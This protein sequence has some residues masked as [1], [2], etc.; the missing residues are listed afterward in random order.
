MKA[1]HIPDLIE[2]ENK[3]FSKPWTY[4]GF[5]A[6]LENETA[7]FF[8]AI[9]DNRIVGY[10]GFHVILDEGYIANIAVS[11]E[12][13]RNGTGSALLGHAVKISREKNL[14]FLSLEVRKS[15][16]NAI[17]LYRKFGFDIVGER[18]NFYSA[19]TENGYIMTLTFNR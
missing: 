13:R 11:P 17:R 12:F 16:E 15:N 9:K 7:N 1:E 2:I 6:E 19:P 8:T 5:K 18:K 3:C 14:A 10:V 4:D